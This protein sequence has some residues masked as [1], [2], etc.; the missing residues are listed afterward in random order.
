MSNKDKIENA[1]YNA[2]LSREIAAEPMPNLSKVAALN[3]PIEGLEVAIKYINQLE[4][5]NEKLIRVIEVH[6]N[7]IEQNCEARDCSAYRDRGL[8][9]PDCPKDYLL[10]E[11]K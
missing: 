6:N 11:V 10:D 7:I 4:A 8:Q 5:E 1:L 2:K 3:D 9:C